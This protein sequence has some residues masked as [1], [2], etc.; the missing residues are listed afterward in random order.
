MRLSLPDGSRKINYGG[1]KYI[2]VDGTYNKK[3]SQAL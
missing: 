1:C 2:L 3:I